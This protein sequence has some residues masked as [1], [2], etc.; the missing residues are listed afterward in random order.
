MSRQ[1]LRVKRAHERPKTS[2]HF[3]R[4]KKTSCC[5]RFL[6]GSHGCNVLVDFRKAT[7]QRSLGSRCYFVSHPTFFQF[8]SLLCLQ[9]ELL[10]RHAICPR[11]QRVAPLWERARVLAREGSMAS[12]CIAG[13]TLIFACQCSLSSPPA[14][15]RSAFAFPSLRRVGDHDH[16]ACARVHATLETTRRR[17]KVNL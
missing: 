7:P 6:G 13:H 14:I 5:A 12:T 2:F 8:P 15:S 1:Q 16:A 3:S 10:R 4:S 11:Q 9:H 17:N